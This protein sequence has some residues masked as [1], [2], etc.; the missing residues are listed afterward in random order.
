MNEVADEKFY[1]R[2]RQLKR[3]QMSIINKNGWTRE[4]NFQ[5]FFL[6][7]QG[8]ELQSNLPIVFVANYGKIS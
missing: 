7:L 6:L 8:V 2:R 3:Q 1:C 4:I 5:V